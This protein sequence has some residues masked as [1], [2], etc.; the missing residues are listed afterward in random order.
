MKTTTVLASLSA[1]L[2]VSGCAYHEKAAG[3]AGAVTEGNEV[4]TAPPAAAPDYPP[5]PPGSSTVPGAPLTPPVL[6]APRAVVPPPDL[7]QNGPVP[8]ADG[9]A[10][11]LPQT[12][13]TSADA[14]DSLVTE[15]KNS[16]D[17]SGMA[18][19]I[20]G[21]HISAQSG[22]IY[23]TGTVPSLRDK[24]MV[25]RLVRSVSGAV[26]VKN[27]LVLSVP[28]PGAPIQI[29]SSL[30]SN[31]PA[32]VVARDVDHIYS[33]APNPIANVPQAPGAIGGSNQNVAAVTGQP[34]TPT[35]SRPVNRVYPE[36]SAQTNVRT[37]ANIRIQGL[38]EA[39]EPV[40]QRIA[41]ELR[42]DRELAALNQAVELR[43]ENG[44]V[45]MRGT[46]KSEQE[47]QAIRAA[48]QRAA[49]NMPVEDH[50][51]LIEPQAQPQPAN[52]QPVYPGT[53]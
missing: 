46:I 31:A 38:T 29:G 40:V 16:L 28:A 4:V 48:I 12:A 47:R 5:A 26:H 7:E 25:D 32:A 9:L 52:P 35:S 17:D 43:V 37:P 51:Q 53:K 27:Q 41:K 34:L 19:A 14:S 23:L 49:G 21:V 18:A 24:A 20:Q 15:I 1:L 6:A 10:S 45:T 44:S 22:T 39:D 3:S 36:A 30:F 8:P 50:L 11:T 13:A 42:W 33:N 2:I